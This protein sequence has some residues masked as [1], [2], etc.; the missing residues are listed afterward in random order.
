MWTGR[1]VVAVDVDRRDDSTVA[2]QH[3]LV[4][5]SA[6]TAGREGQRADRAVVRWPDQ[7]VSGEDGRLWWQGRRSWFLFIDVVKIVVVPHHDVQ[8]TKT[9]L[10]VETRQR[11]LDVFVVVDDRVD[12]VQGLAEV[13]IL[14]L[15]LLA[16]DGE[17]LPTQCIDEEGM[18]LEVVMVVMILVIV[19]I[20]LVRP[21]STAAAATPSSSSSTPL[22][23]I[24]RIIQL[25]IVVI[26]EIVFPVVWLP[27]TRRET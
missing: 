23:F 14:L 22:V 3:G 11:I 20:R 19:R 5:E 26:I 1:N 10:H 12:A 25:F 9:W 21:A 15:L 7:V 18:F 6:S 8:L 16:G 27:L 13:L 17:M 24:L 2:A 4:G